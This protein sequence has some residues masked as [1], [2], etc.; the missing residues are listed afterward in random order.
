MQQKA[1]A[2]AQ[3]EAETEAG[4]V[5]STTQEKS[6]VKSILQLCT[7]VALAVDSLKTDAKTGK[8]VWKDR[9]QI[10]ESF[11]CFSTWTLDAGRGKLAFNLNCI[12]IRVFV[13]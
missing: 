1:E 2:E 3:A 7:L 11:A 13:I 4:D 5:W 9:R 12:S 10:N 6:Q 8:T